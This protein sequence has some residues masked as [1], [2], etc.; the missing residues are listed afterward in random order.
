MKLVVLLNSFWNRSGGDARAIELV[1]RWKRRPDPNAPDDLTRAFAPSEVHVIAPRRI[2]R[3]L[4]SKQQ[5]GVVMHWTEEADEPGGVMRCYARRL[6]RARRILDEICKAD[7]AD[8]IVYSSSGFFP[9]VLPGAHSARRWGARWAGCCF[10]LIEHPSTRPGSPLWNWLSYAEQR[11]C[12]RKQRGQQLV[13]VDNN[14]LRDWLVGHGGFQ[15]EQV[16]VLPCGVEVPE[17][18]PPASPAPRFDLVFCGRVKPSK[19]ILDFVAVAQAFRRRRAD[20]AKLRIGVVGDLDE[21]YAATVRTAAAAAEVDLQLLG[22]LDDAAKR[23]VLASSRLFVSLSH[24][25]GWGIV[26][27]EAFAA[28]L[29]VVAY[30][31]PCYREVFPGL[32]PTAPV[33]DAE[34]IAAHVDRLLAHPEEAAEQARRGRE[35][36]REHYAYDTLAEREGALLAARCRNS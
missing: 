9:D 25:E 1:Q 22:G 17:T 18:P 2:E 32:F 5:T 26:V 11:Y 23:D 24:E 8:T 13:I 14:A 3:Q 10:H 7:A 30:D 20:S 27:A 33:G 29:P 34:G 28:G 15:S 36:V 12:L 4:P 21:A 6:I 31:L 35:Y 19:G 16:H